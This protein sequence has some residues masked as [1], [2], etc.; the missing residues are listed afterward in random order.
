[1]PYGSGSK[2]P[3]QNFTFLSGGSVAVSTNA[4]APSSFPLFE[5]EG[6][7]SPELL[8]DAATNSVFNN[9]PDIGKLNGTLSFQPTGA[10]GDFVTL[11]IWSEMS[12]D[13]INWT[14]IQDSLRTAAIK[15]NEDSYV[16][17]SSRGAQFPSKNYVRWQMFSDGP[18]N[19]EPPAAHNAAGGSVGGVSVVW[20]LVSV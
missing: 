16:T 18:I 8:L 3:K 13:G 12:A 17:L 14:P 2:Q 11:A 20:E 6:T 15:G 19:I 1:M 4:A 7:S 10:G 9:G 5:R